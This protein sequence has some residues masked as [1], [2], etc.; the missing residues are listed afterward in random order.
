MIADRF[1]QEGFSIRAALPS[2]LEGLAALYPHLNPSDE[3][4]ARDLAASR[5]DAIKQIPGS[6]VLLGLRGDE[7]VGVHLG[8]NPSR[9]RD[10]W[11]DRSI[12]RESSQLLIS[13]G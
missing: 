11:M 12:E 10:R 6:A 7:A 2:D 5:L 1:N 4:I 8:E 9:Q 13:W 3:P